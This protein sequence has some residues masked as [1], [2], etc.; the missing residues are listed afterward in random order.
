MDETPEQFFRNKMRS[1]FNS[2]VTASKIKKDKE[3]EQNKDKQDEDKKI[4]KP[5]K[6]RAPKQKI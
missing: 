4:I 5:K 1:L 2:S 3:Q 6:K